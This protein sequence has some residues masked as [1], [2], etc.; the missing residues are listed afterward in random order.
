MCQ[1]NRF[2]AQIKELQADRELLCTELDDQL[3]ANADLRGLVQEQTRHLF[4]AERAVRQLQRRVEALEHDVA[5]YGSLAVGF[6]GLV[7]PPPKE[8]PCD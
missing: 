4:L 6:G 1:C 8:A 2:R 3:T 7:P 5:F